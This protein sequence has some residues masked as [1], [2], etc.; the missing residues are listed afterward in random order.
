VRQI[1]Q[2]E[3]LINNK[4][5]QEEELEFKKLED[6]LAEERRISIEK[7]NLDTD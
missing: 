4:L 7:L 6:Q 1:R 5:Q 3:E 2:E